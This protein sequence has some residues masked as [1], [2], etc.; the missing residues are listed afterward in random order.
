MKRKYTTEYLTTEASSPKSDDDM[1]N[2]CVKFRQD[3]PM[4]RFC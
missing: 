4:S 1:N 2:W 3:L